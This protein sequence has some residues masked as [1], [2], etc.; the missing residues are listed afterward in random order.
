MSWKSQPLFSGASQGNEGLNIELRLNSNRNFDHR[1]SLPLD[2]QGSGIMIEKIL[3]PKNLYKAYQKVVSNKGSAGVGGTSVYKLASYKD[4]NRGQP[5][6]SILNRKYVPQAIKR[7]EIPKGKDKTRPLG[8]PTVV[9]RWLQQSVGRQL[10]V[11]S[12][13][14]GGPSWI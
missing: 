3:Q 10:A 6:T 9:D 2:R 1:D 8:I 11:K 12:D 13:R 14:G 4:E 7:V 5:A